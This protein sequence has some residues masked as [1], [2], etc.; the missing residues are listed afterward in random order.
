MASVKAGDAATTFM[1]MSSKYD[2]AAAKG[3]ADGYKNSGLK[4]GNK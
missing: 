2:A 4:N 1:Q 3:N